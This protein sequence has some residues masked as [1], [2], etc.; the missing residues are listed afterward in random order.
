[1]SLSATPGGYHVVARRDKA[2][3]VTIRFDARRRTGPAWDG[4]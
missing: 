1:M 4:G 2:E 3:P